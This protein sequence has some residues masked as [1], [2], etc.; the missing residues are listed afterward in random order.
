VIWLATRPLGWNLVDDVREV[1]SYDFMRN[2][3]LAGTCIALAAGLVGYFIVLRNQVFTSDALGHVAFSGGLAGAILGIPLLAGVYASTIAVS[4]GIGSFGGRGRGRDVAIGIVFA[5]VLGLGVLFL[6]IYT[7]G[8]GTSNGVLGVAVLFGSILGLQAP[9]AYF[10]A[11]ASLATCALLL[12][13]CRPL[14][15]S[16]LDPDVAAARGVPTRVVSAIFLVLLA[17]TVAESVQAIG[18]LL[19]FAL[20]V[21]PGAVAQRLTARPYRALWLSAGLAV[22]FVWL[23][24]GLAFYTPWPA[25]SYITAIAF[26]S[27]LVVLLG[28]GAVRRVDG[29]RR[30]RAN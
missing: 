4:L 12:A 11:G 24:L 23:G 18:A 13:V 25:S 3:L 20:L 29:A 14:L 28:G 27:L 26:A 22:G 16:S 17:L 21:T 8:Q 7:T 19:I 30:Q 9:Q 15:F 10:A 5:W 6:S 2:A 1:L